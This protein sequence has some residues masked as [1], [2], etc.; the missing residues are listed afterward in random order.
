M[1]VVPP[2]GWG[3]VGRGKRMGSSALGGGRRAIGLVPW[4]MCPA[5]P[6]VT[7]SLELGVEV[8]EDTASECL[9]LL[10]NAGFLCPH[11]LLPPLPLLLAHVSSRNS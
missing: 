8:A 3:G 5:P 7:H 2:G 9:C 10:E 4:K 11:P 6:T 1:L